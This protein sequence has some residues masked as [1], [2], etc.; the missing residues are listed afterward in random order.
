MPASRDLPPGEGL[1]DARQAAELLGV[2]RSTLYAYASRGWVRTAPASGA[3][4]GGARARLYARAD[5]DRLK[6]RHDARAGHGAVAA[7][8]LRWGEP[9]LESSLTRID[10]RGH[11]Y[12]GQSALELAARG[13]RFE[14]VCELLW[15]GQLRDR[16][17]LTPGAAAT[18][19]AVSRVA[20]AT[21]VV[22]RAAA[23]SA[24]AASTSAEAMLRSAPR[25]PARRGKPLR[26][27]AQGLGLAHLEDLIPFGAPPLAGL[28]LAVPALGLVDPGRFDAPFEAEL[29]RARELVRMMSALLA[30][31]HGA[32]R[33]A[34]ALTVGRLTSSVA[35]SALAALSP[36]RDPGSLPS[37]A[38][39]TLLDRAL[40]LSA[41]HELNPSSFAA[42]VAGSVGADLYACV[43]AALATLSG[44]RHGG[45]CDRVE[46]LLAE[47]ERPERAADVLFERSAR[48]ES[49]PG[50]GHHLYPRGDPRGRMLLEAAA[51]H[52]P[53]AAGVRRALALAKVMRAT[54][55]E[56]PTLDLGLCAVAAALDLPRGAPVALFALGRAAGWIAHALEQRA[57][58]FVLRPRARYVG[59]TGELPSGPGRAM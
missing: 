34:A 4:P 13:V 52:A 6:A 51:A 46:A 29:T 49:I 57:A 53:R 30:L 45:M 58:G 43:T 17:P 40:V 11:S 7:G 59:P 16:L 23:Q 24:E 28:S 22:S 21:A 47:V 48:G 50:F 55:R 12:R 54:R 56:E 32:G 15:T 36:P 20:G 38:R 5:L 1:L 42:R 3:Q 39:I 10:E 33:V 44:P 19:A 31:A 8:A 27:P 25:P 9:V 26:A 2:K 14:A 41:D 37:R 35:A 18:A